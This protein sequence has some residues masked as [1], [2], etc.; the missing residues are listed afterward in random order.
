[1]RNATCFKC[2]KRGH[3]ESVCRATTDLGEVSA[4][5]T[6]KR[7]NYFVEVIKQLKACSKILCSS[8]FLNY[9]VPVN[10]KLDTGADVTV[11]SAPGYKKY[12][13]V[14]LMKPSRILRG[15]T[16]HFLK[17]CWS[18]YWNLRGVE[19]KQEAFVVHMPL[20]GHPAIETLCLFV[21][22]DSFGADA[23]NHISQLFP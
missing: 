13:K 4:I 6:V 12:F 19:V 7:D 17:G 14:Q 21:K 23:K 20:I 15:P 3:F 10:F 16:Q 5:G 9:G 11:I 1:M 2:S 8:L 22:V 18:V